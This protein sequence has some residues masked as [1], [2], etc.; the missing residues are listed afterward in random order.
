MTGE[1]GKVL[2]R[3]ASTHM[4]ADVCGDGL[5]SRGN[6]T[7]SQGVSGYTSYRVRVEPHTFGTLARASRSSPTDP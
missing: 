7:R 5:P 4:I 3:F 6:T 2:L 1:K